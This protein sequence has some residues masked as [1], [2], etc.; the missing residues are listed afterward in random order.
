MAVFGEGEEAYQI[1]AHEL[2]TP[3]TLVQG[4]AEA[5]ASGL[6]GPLLPEQEDSVR[7]IVEYV[8]HLH[9]LVER[10][11]TFQALLF[12][13]MPVRQI[14]VEVD[15]LIL[16]VVEKW[17][18]LVQGAVSFKVDIVRPAPLIKGDPDLLTQVLDLLIE[19]AVKFS[20]P[21]QRRNV[22][23]PGIQGALSQLEDPGEGDHER[24]IIVQAWQNDRYVRWAIRDSG[25]GIPP[26]ELERVFEPF[27]QMDQSTTRQYEGMGLGLSLCRAI[28]QAHGGFIWAESEGPSRGT[29]FHIALPRARRP[30]SDH[31]HPPAQ[32]R[33]WRDQPQGIFI[34]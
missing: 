13:A 33:D 14:S 1:L 22:D 16:S 15:T 9:T 34:R 28:I 6:L 26:E 24:C 30:F 4:Y 5:L 25:I 20:M 32:E 29:T 12:Q 10:L 7:K 31:A 2:R 23:A 19:N 18:H 27:Y 8:R 21:P 17:R 11:L 3:L